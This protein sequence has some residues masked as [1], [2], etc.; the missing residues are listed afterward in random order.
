MECR[1]SRARAGVGGGSSIDAVLG[2]RFGEAAIG[3]ALLATAAVTLVVF[4]GLRGRR[5]LAPLAL[6]VAATPTLG[7]A[8]HAGVADTAW[9]AV[10]LDA[11]HLIAAGVWTG[12]LLALVLTYRAH[13]QLPKRARRPFLL[14]A[15]R[16]FSKIAIGGLVV[17]SLTGTVAAIREVGSVD[18]LTATS[19]G[20]VLLLKVAFVAAAV[21]VASRTRRADRRF[22]AAAC[23]EL[24]AFVAVIL[25]TAL[26]TGLA[27]AADAQPSGARYAAITRPLGGYELSFSLEPLTAGQP[28]ETHVVLVD[29]NGQPAADA[30]NATLTASLPG[31]NLEELPI[32]M[33]RITPGHW[34]GTAILPQPGDWTLDLVVRSGQFEQETTTLD[35]QIRS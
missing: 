17:V 1:W 22:A 29:R 14:G 20:R 21:A 6:V 28:A 7:L 3:R 4:A 5:A 19:Y 9:L 13:G 32:A 2:T 18:A 24:G 27:P 11:L 26:L 16:R 8:G 12:G 10:S 23:T 34:V 31:T 33:Q 35:V 30:E 15:V 25:A